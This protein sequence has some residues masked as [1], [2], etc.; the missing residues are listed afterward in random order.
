M[1]DVVGLAGGLLATVVGVATLSALLLWPWNTPVS[2]VFSLR[3]I[4][5]W[6]A[7]KLLLIAGILF[8]PPSAVGCT[9]DR[10]S[11]AVGQSENES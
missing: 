3:A 2:D 7:H 1:P 6:Q 9:C 5:F 8:G 4:T 11:A 10:Q